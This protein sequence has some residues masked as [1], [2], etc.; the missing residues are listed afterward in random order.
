MDG[1]PNMTLTDPGQLHPRIVI[2][3][4]GL[5]GLSAAK[6]LAKAPLDVRIQFQLLLSQVSTA[7]LS[8]GDI[9]S[10]IRGPLE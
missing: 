1:K 7:R 8:P 6:H 10:P 9:V 3:G 4:S 2:I 5:G